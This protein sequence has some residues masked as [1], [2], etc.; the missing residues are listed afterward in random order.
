MLDLNA[1][2]DKSDF[3]D[4]LDAEQKARLDEIDEIIKDF[5]DNLSKDQQGQSL[6]E[7]INDRL[8]VV[9]LNFGNSGQDILKR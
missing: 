7:W 3:F 4:S 1:V 5:F 8:V 6:N 9:R 2:E